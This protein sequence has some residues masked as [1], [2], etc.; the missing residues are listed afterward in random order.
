MNNLLS[1]LISTLKARITP[2]WTKLRYWTSWNFIKANILTKIRNALTNLFVVKPRDKDDY[3]PIFGLL[4]SKRLARAIVIVVGILGLC[5]FLWLNPVSNMIEG[6]GSSEKIYSYNSLPLRFAQGNV[7]IKAK[8]GHIAYI[9]NVADGYAT[10]QGALYDKE[11]NLV[12]RGNFDLNKYNGQGTLYYANGQEKYK[13][14]FRNNVFAGEGT[15]FRENG[16]KQYSGQF[17][18]GVFEG[19]GTLFNNANVGVFTGNFQKGELAYLQLLGKTTTEIAEQYTG[20]RHIYQSESQWIVIMEDIG[21]FYVVPTENVSVDNSVKS[22]AIYVGKEEFAYAG[23]KFTTIEELKEVLGEP[24]FEGNSYV[25]FSEAV[26][27][28]WLQQSGKV[29]PVNAGVEVL[30]QFDEVSQVDS[31]SADA[32][33]YLYIFQVEDVTYTFVAQDRNSGFFMYVLE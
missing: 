9:G 17:A 28:H 18:D 20:N 24:I 2:L 10:G 6:A 13:G 3:Y 8:A 23:E 27:I 4:I 29:I 12:Y 14:E 1:V 33:V 32:L 21:A 16:S 26:G 22:S 30:Q 19:E 11:G 7:K 5:Y 25:N 31:Y 15:L